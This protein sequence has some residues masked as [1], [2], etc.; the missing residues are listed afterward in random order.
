MPKTVL[1]G[2][3]NCDTVRKARKWLTA[4]GID[5]TFHDL[6][7]D[8][9]N[10]KQLKCWVRELGWETL[11]N[12]RGMMWRKLPDK[13]KENLD[14]K[15]AIAIMLTEPAIIKRPLLDTGKQRHVGF[16]EDEYKQLF[17]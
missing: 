17:K 8:G 16:S 5:F 11:L 13:Q 6:R 12:K 15:K 7:K 4:N 1:Y 2:I 14:E 10:A 9:L 3:S